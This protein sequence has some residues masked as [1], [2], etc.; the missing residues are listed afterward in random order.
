MP[1]KRPHCP[2]PLAAW[3]RKMGSSAA[4]FARLVGC[5]RRTAQLWVNGQCLPSLIYAYKIDEITRGEVPPASWLGTEIGKAEWEA[6]G[7][8]ARE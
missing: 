3:L 4:S 2:T 6:K 5:N 1:D 8:A 7:R